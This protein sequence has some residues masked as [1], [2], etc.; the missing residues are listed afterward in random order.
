MVGFAREGGAIVSRDEA[1][2]LASRWLGVPGDVVELREFD[3]GWV[4]FRGVADAVAGVLPDRVGDARVVVDRVTGKVTSWPPLPVEEIIARSRGTE[5]RRFPTDI[6][7]YLRKSGWHPGRSIPDEDIDRFAL[8]LG[9][10]PA[11]PRATFG[12]VDETR[13]VLREFGGLVID[14]PGW[15]TWAMQ[16]ADFDPD[17]ALVGGLDSKIGQAITPIGAMISPFNTEILMSEDGRVFY[18]SEAGHSHYLLGETFDWA[19]VRALQGDDRILPW[20]GR[21]GQIHYTDFAGEPIDPAT[22]RGPSSGEGLDVAEEA[23][24]ST[25]QRDDG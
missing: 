1:A 14:R 8:H 20:V 17:M 18:A 3:E 13:A 10:L 21:D 11:R 7:D 24:H 22:T 2:E 9:G 19:L 25:D 4:A 5:M 6:E 15:V 12:V 16:P 23:Q